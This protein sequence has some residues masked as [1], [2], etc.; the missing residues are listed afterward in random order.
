MGRSLTI[1]Q[2]TR[3]YDEPGFKP[4]IPQQ[5]QIHMVLANI[6]FQF[7]VRN[8]QTTEQRNNFN[9]LSNKH[10]HFALSK[11]Y[12]I[13]SSPKFEAFQ[14]LVLLATHTR[15]FPKPGCGSIVA[16]MTLH[17]AL[18]LNL[19][20]N[21][22]RPG[23]PTDLQNEL[24]KR[25]WWCTLAIVVAISGKRGNHVP[26]SVQDF[27]VDYPEPIADELLSEEGVDTSR[28]LPCPYELAICG[29]KLV[30]TLMEMYAH[31]C[32]LRRDPSN[33]KS[34]LSALEA[35]LELWEAELPDSM[36]L[37]T[38]R[39][40]DHEMIGPLYVRTYALEFRLQIRHPS[41]AM[42]T[43][44]DMIAENTNICK[45]AAREYLE[46]VESLSKM[47]ALDT[48][49]YQMTVYCVSILS[50]L[51]PQWQ[52]RYE[53]THEDFVQL[54][55]EMDRW[56]NIVKEMSTL[57]GED[58]SRPETRCSVSSELTYHRLWQRHE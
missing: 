3:V 40:Q 28:T 27:D 21:A 35:Q 43:D 32:S 15:G 42:T 12:D 45:Q 34:V 16:C 47:K 30:P 38:P 11:M 18:E 37:S 49:W 23:E 46:A 44:R 7:G 56:M 17:R 22:K 2:L 20:R 52:R 13:F 53:V 36:R 39:G 41:L 1:Y 6:M 10:Y 8:S 58:T 55:S 26:I 9:D 19:H 5:V 24:R 54:E 57:L 50:L 14:G 48:T 29:F 33:Y 51:V 4:S 25:A 31:V